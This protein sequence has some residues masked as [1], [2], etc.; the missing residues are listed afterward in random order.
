MGWVTF[1]RPQGETM[2]QTFEREFGFNKPDHK[3]KMLD[4]AT[5]L[6]YV[7]I[8]VEDPVLGVFCVIVEVKFYRGPGK[9]YDTNNFGYKDMDEDMGV[10]AYDC[11]ER[12]LD[13]LTEPH[14][15]YAR[16]WRAECRRRIAQKK[17]RPK[18]YDGCFIC[19]DTP[20]S[21]RSWGTESVFKVK[22]GKG[23]PKF[24]SK[25]GY[26]HFVFSLKDRPYTV[27]D[28][29]TEAEEAETRKA[30]A[31]EKEVRPA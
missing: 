11:P 9:S 22:A 31:A 8:A 1:M 26:T 2:R 25:S 7:Y 20:L 6:P 24:Y 23:R 12:I 29:V 10:P 16:E 13:L 27:H 30:K 14:S 3:Q 15:D 5:V 17:G 18:L 4:I 19:L 21:F 28:T